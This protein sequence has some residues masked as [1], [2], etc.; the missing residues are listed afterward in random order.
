M[1]KTITFLGLCFIVSILCSK[2]DAFFAIAIACEKYGYHNQIAYKYAYGSALGNSILQVQDDLQQ[3]L[4]DDGIKNGRERD[5]FFRS[6][7]IEHGFFAIVR[8]IAVNVSEPG[9]Y[10]AVLGVGISKNDPLGAISNAREDIKKTIEKIN[11][12]VLIGIFEE[13]SSDLFEFGQF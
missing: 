12:N 2:L 3:D 8:G 4:I 11:T 10:V 7:S 5:V 6:S 9:V 1:R 13:I